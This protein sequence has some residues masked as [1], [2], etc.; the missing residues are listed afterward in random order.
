[1]LPRFQR[2]ATEL[3]RYRRQFACPVLPVNGKNA[4]AARNLQLA[5]CNTLE[6]AEFYDYWGHESTS[7][8]TVNVRYLGINLSFV[9]G[10]NEP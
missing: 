6:S 2:A 7:P 8:R 3:L 4:A 9:G 1:M 5:F 10:Q